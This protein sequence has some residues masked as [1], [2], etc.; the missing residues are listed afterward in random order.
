MVAAEL[1]RATGWVNG[2]KFGAEKE[3][4]TVARE[5]HAGYGSGSDDSNN[6]EARMEEEIEHNNRGIVWD[7]AGA[8]RLSDLPEE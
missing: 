1:W 8:R 3:Y 5:A 2:D 4:S 6:M 7:T